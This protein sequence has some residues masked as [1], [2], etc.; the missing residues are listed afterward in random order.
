MS[1]PGGS[2]APHVQLF[3]TNKIAGNIK[4][5]ELNSYEFL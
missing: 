5:E 3:F 2:R 4:T 1:H